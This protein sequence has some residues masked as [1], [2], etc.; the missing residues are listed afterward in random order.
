M[1]EIILFQVILPVLSVIWQ[2]KLTLISNA[3]DDTAYYINTAEDLWK[4]AE[5]V[6]DGNKFEGITVYLAKSNVK[7]CKS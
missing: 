6:N 3:E 5:E 4:F 2:S 7:M 1:G